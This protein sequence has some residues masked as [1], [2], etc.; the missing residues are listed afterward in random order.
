L[1]DVATGY[2]PAPLHRQDLFIHVEDELNVPDCE[3]E[4]AVVI[5]LKVPDTV[6]VVPDAE[7][8]KL[9]LAD[10]EP[11]ATASSSELLNSIMISITISY[12]TVDVVCET[13]KTSFSKLA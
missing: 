7:F 12:L 9:K 4:E 1:R 6:A 8:V 13:A 11:P 5:W 10:P 3:A 2:R